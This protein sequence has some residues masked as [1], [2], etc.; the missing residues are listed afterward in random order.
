MAE[1]LIREYELDI[2]LNRVRNMTS[3]KES[4]QEY[5]TDIA[6]VLRNDYWRFEELR[7]RRV[8]ERCW[9]NHSVMRPGPYSLKVSEYQC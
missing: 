6:R 7:R 1:G 3:L 9:R 8:G 2:K 4:A 5:C